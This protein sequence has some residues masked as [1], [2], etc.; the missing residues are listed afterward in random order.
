LP[1]AS[2]LFHVDDFHG[3][4]EWAQFA[5]QM[6]KVFPDR[7]IVDLPITH[8]IFHTFFDIDHIIQVPNVGLGELWKA[9]GG[10]SIGKMNV[11]FPPWPIREFRD[12]SDGI[13]IRA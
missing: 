3:G 6:K 9:S 2:L 10:R 8:P 13:R 5:S 7:E 12:R 1:S 4:R 11:V